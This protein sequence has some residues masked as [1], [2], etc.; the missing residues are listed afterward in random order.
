[1][2]HNY[3]KKKLKKTILGS[4][5]V[6]LISWI[7]IGLY[8]NLSNTTYKKLEKVGYSN[9]EISVIEDMLKKGNVKIVYKNKYMPYLTSIIFDQDFNENNL[10]DY[11]NYYQKYPN[12][13]EDKLLF[14]VNNDLDD[15]E[16]NS[17]IE[18]IIYHDDFKKDLLIRYDDYHNKY[19]LKVDDT[20]YA[21]NHDLDLFDIKLD[22]NDKKY[23]ENKYFIPNN[24]NRYQNYFKKN[25]LLSAN[26]VIRCVNSNLDKTPYVNVVKATTK[27]NIPI[28]VNKYY[29]L[30]VN[31]I[32]KLVNIDKTYGKGKLD[33]EA[34]EAFIKMYNEAKKEKLNLY[35]VTGY[36]SYEE[37][38][39]LYFKYSSLYGNNIDKYYERPGYAESQTGLSVSLG[40]LKDQ[41]PNNFSLYNESNWMKNNAYKFGFILR[42]PSDKQK[43][44]GY[45]RNYY[46]RYVGDEAA[47]YIKDNN[48]SL[49]EYYAYF[50][51]KK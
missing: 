11:L 24:L 2:H 29:Y 20:I 9:K 18:K 42:Y 38:T 16:Y 50:I 45:S 22:T 28:L 26:E 10:T 33:K 41:N 44:T 31:F 51:N 36:V 1:M 8:L 19:K 46:Y 30:G 47:K 4:I 6:I 27:D 32:P 35:I 12:I 7:S 21:V 39:N 13:K 48:L 43:Y 17:F 40:T 15:V 49:E 25:K 3:K 37:Q 23:I 5:S 34:Y 14:M